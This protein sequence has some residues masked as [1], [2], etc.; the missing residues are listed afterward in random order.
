MDGRG[1]PVSAAAEKRNLGIGLPEPGLN[2]GASGVRAALDAECLWNLRPQA[3]W[4]WVCIHNELLKGWLMA[5]PPYILWH[6]YMDGHPYLE[7]S[8][9]LNESSFLFLSNLHS[10]WDNRIS[11]RGSPNPRG[12][13]RLH[14]SKYKTRI[15]W[16]LSDS[17]GHI[18][19]GI[20]EIKK[21][22]HD[23]HGWWCRL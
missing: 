18:E 12:I 23:D 15:C 10:T 11:L 19:P 16:P 17:L 7:A 21:K 6:L 2:E 20:G 22:S 9:L 14:V 1:R 13:S 3:G 4:S 8:Y 5:R